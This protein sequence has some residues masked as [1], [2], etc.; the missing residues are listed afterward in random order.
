VI[1]PPFETCDEGAN[2]GAGSNCTDTCKCSDCGDAKVDSD[3]STL[4]ASCSANHPNQ[5]PA[6]SNPATEKCDDGNAVNTDTCLNNCNLNQCGDGVVNTINCVP[7]VA[8]PGNVCGTTVEQCDPGG[9]GD[10]IGTNCSRSCCLYESA[11]IPANQPD[12]ATAVAALRCCVVELRNAFIA[13]NLGALAKRA[14]KIIK[15]IDKKLVGGIGKK[16]CRGYKNVARKL[17]QLAKKIDQAGT[18]P[19]VQVELQNHR[20]RC[21]RWANRVGNLAG[22][23]P[24]F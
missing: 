3:T 7:H 6:N 24:I 19:A 22:C 17:S 13:N 21:A 9:C 4:P 5:T 10:N 14:D 1:D 2:N 12:F 18:P 16:T 15:Q 23:A 20:S 11:N 8:C